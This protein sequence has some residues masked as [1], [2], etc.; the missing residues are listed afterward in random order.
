MP[1]VL[2]YSSGWPAPAAVKAGKYVGV[3]RYVG[4][5]GHAK[6]LTRAEAQAM[7]AGGIPIGL[8]YEAT[9]GW[10]LG[11]A[12]AGAGAARA[13]LAD[14]AQC[15]VGVRCVYFACD[16]DITTASAMAGVQRCLDGAASVLGIERTG[17]YGEADVI[18]QCVPS[19]AAWGWQTRAWSGGRVSAKASLLQQI[20]YVDVGGV[21]CDRNTVL[22]ADWGQWPAAGEDLAMDADTKTYLDNQFTALRNG[23]QVTWYGDDRDDTKDLGTHPYNLQA[24]ATGQQAQARQLAAVAG[25]VDALAAAVANVQAGT[26]DPAAVAASIDLQALAQLLAPQIA[27]HVQLKAV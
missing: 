7:A 13:A 19:H 5:P 10:M 12:A 25:K 18:D 22:K 8:V 17:V 6:N 23:L 16:V 3:V 1:D 20:G 9:A 2:D 27:A 15:G 14:A 24:L 21:Q 11:G 26:V 4:T